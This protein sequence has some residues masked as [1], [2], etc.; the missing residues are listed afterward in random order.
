[1]I[2]LLQRAGDSDF[3]FRLRLRDELGNL[4]TDTTGELVI[5]LGP[6]GGI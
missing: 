4:L 3:E 6:E 1:M 5:V 2:K